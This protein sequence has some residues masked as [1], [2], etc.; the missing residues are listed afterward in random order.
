MNSMLKRHLAPL[1]DEAWAEIDAEARRGL[2]HF[3][4]ARR[5]VEVDGPHGWDLASVNT[6]KLASADSTVDGVEMALR[7]SLPLVEL[8]T[9]FEMPMEEVDALDR[10][11]PIDLAPVLQAA[12]RAAYAED[13]LVYD[14]LPGTGIVGLVQGSPH[15][16]VSIAEDYSRYLNAVA[17]AVQ[18]L[19]AAG[20]DG[21]YG[22]GLGTDGHRGVIETTERGGYP[23]LEHLRLI[24]GG[25]VVW[26]PAI[27]DALVVSMRGG[28]FEI[29]CGHDFSVGYVEHDSEKLV[30]ALRNSVT[31]RNLGPDAAIALRLED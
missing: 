6:G 27:E 16:P 18:E 15:E 2:D 23:V 29:V 3:L 28:D 24:L 21:P 13:R 14:G 8:E 5:L 4:S 17:T 25:P 31:F 26:A 7:Q 1:S 10:G 30:L 12:R 9:T 11:A 20:I 22:I 19:R